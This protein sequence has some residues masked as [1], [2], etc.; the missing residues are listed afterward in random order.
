MN[1]QKMRKTVPLLMAVTLWCFGIQSTVSAGEGTLCKTDIKNLL[2]TYEKALNE[3]DVNTIVPLYSDSG[4]FMPANKPTAAGQ[5]QVKIAYQHVFKAIDLDIKFHIDEIEYSGD[6]AFVRTTSDGEITIKANNMTI[7]NNSRELF[8]MKKINDEWKI[9][10]Y[11][12]NE[13]SSPKQS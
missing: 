1:I 7:K 2:S 13:V 5:D 6:Y 9:H 3:N 12:F 10:R 11:M 8:V 4:V